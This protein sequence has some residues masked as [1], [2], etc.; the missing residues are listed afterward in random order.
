MLP[1]P[2]LIFSNGSEVSETQ[3]ALDMSISHFNVQNEQQAHLLY[4]DSLMLAC[5]ILTARSS[6]LRNLFVVLVSCPVCE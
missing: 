1:L 3:L 5:R 4:L 2:L 6:L